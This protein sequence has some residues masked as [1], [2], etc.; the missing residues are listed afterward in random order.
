[1]ARS[2]PKQHEPSCGLAVVLPGGRQIEV[3]PDFDMST[4]ERLAGPPDEE[5]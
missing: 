3:C 1:V 2:S 5:A 4:C